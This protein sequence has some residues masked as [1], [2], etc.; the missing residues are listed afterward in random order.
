MCGE[1]FSLFFNLRTVNQ[2]YPL[3]FINIKSIEFEN[4]VTSKVKMCT[5]LFFAFNHILVKT[6]VYPVDSNV[7]R[8]SLQYIIF[9]NHNAFLT[10]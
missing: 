5:H 10:C 2:L 6:A 9:I 8:G 7:F 1:N 4:T 3:H